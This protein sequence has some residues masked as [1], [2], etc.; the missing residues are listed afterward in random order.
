MSPCPECSKGLA[1]FGWSRLLLPGMGSILSLVGTELVC[2]HGVLSITYL[3]DMRVTESA[4]AAAAPSLLQNEVSS[5]SHLPW[6]EMSMAAAMACGKVCSA[7]VPARAVGLRSGCRG[8]GQAAG[9]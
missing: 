8:R 4:E 3:A 2:W 5:R 9:G 6:L 1:A 7:M